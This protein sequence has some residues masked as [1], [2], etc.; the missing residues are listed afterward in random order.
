M[1]NSILIELKEFNFNSIKKIFFEFNLKNSDPLRNLIETQ[2]E[3]LYFN[4][5]QKIAFQFIF[6]TLYCKAIRKF[7]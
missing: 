4:S 2:I 7:N 6:K 1:E 5:I 3:N